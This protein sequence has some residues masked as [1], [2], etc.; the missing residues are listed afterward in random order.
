MHGMWRIGFFG[1]KWMIKV[2]GHAVETDE[3]EIPEWRP[4]AKAAADCG[5][6]PQSSSISPAIRSIQSSPSSTACCISIIA[7]AV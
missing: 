4:V 1:G 5:L 3:A 6:V 7:S 2:V